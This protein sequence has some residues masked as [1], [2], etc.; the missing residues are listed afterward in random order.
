MEPALKKK[1]IV[2]DNVVI[3]YGRGLGL[4]TVV[5]INIH[6]E[7]LVSWETVGLSL[8]APTSLE[9]VDPTELYRW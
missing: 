3:K 7:V 2:G 6:G 5:V 9:I 1:L 8:H 4:G